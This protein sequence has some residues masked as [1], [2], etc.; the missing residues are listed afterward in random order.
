MPNQD[1]VIMTKAYV[2]GLGEGIRATNV[3]INPRLFCPPPKLPLGVE[4]FVDVLDRA[5]KDLSVRLP[6]PEVEAKD[7]SV[8]LLRGLVDTF[9]CA[10]DKH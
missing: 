9:P 2:L 5:I 10:G 4:N 3:L 7:I 8:V 6:N 1:G